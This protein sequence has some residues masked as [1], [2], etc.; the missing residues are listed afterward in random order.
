[1]IEFFSHSGKPLHVVL[2][3][4][5]KLSNQERTNTLRLVQKKIAEYGFIN[6]SVQLFSS[7]K[8]TGVPELEDK[9]NE[10][11]T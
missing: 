6:L 8:K 7:L 11:L 2:S 1:M 3:K 9:L 5:D 10:W 4:A